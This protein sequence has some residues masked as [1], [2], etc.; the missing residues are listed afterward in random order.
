V[1][2]RLP[3]ES[4]FGK[5]NTPLTCDNFD[6][7]TPVAP[8]LHVFIAVLRI[9]GSDLIKRWGNRWE[10]RYILCEVCAKSLRTALFVVEIVD[11][12]GKVEFSGEIHPVGFI[13]FSPR[14]A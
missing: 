1:K 13:D 11:S 3:L 4:Y 10:S 14:H 9:H 7:R 6:C 12:R 5:A 2:I 8:P